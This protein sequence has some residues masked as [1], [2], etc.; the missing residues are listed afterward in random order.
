MLNRAQNECENTVV[1]KIR[2]S[3]YI[4]IHTYIHI[5][6]YVCM[7]VYMYIYIY[8]YIYQIYNKKYYE[9]LLRTVILFI[10]NIFY[11]CFGKNVLWWYV[12]VICT[13]DNLFSCLHLVSSSMCLF[14]RFFVEKMM[15]Y[16]SV[17]HNM[18]FFETGQ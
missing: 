15:W 6:I 16:F 13:I 14:N 11:N 9:R 2:F 10:D 8:I 17:R 5:Y 4:Y 1:L 18:H 3:I 7:Y 12:F